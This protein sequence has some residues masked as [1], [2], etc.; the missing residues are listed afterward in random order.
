MAGGR[1]S[2]DFRVYEVNRQIMSKSPPPESDFFPIY[3]PVFYEPTDWFTKWNLIEELKRKAIE[4]EEAPM[5]ETTF[6]KSENQ[7]LREKIKA[8]ERVS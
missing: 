6:L 3:F 7:E 1:G 2:R 5:R 8:L 4:R